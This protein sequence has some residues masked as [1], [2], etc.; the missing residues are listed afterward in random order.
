M[1]TDT[2]MTLLVAVTMLLS[3][4]AHEERSGLWSFALAGAAAGLA[5][6]TSTTAAWR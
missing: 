3:L 4:R 6:A 1:L 5:A 2:P